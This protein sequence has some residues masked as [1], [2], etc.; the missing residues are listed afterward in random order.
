MKRGGWRA[1]REREGWRGVTL[2]QVDPHP[3]VEPCYISGH[4]AAWHCHNSDNDD[5]DGGLC[6]NEEA[7][8]Y[9]DDIIVPI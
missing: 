1:G 9:H 7:I 2:S 6:G 3:R 4:K 5:D 8:N